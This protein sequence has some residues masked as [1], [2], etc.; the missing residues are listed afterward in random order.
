MQ[1]A[2]TEQLAAL[3]KVS[4]N[5]TPCGNKSNVRSLLRLSLKEGDWLQAYFMEDGDGEGNP[6]PD[7]ETFIH[8]DKYCAENYLCDFALAAQVLEIT[9]DEVQQKLWAAIMAAKDRI[10][11]KN[12]FFAFLIDR[13]DVTDITADKL[14]KLDM[15]EILPVFLRAV[16]AERDQYIVSYLAAAKAAG[17]LPEVMPAPLLRALE[18]VRDATGA[19]E[20]ELQLVEQDDVAAGVI[21]LSP[22][23]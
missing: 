21:A 22:T 15:A 16:H 2:L 18:A 19:T 10:F 7:I 13:L 3:L 8:L 23:Q 1:V 12:K 20:A 6:F 11:V 4:I 14:A 9:E 17:R 5:I